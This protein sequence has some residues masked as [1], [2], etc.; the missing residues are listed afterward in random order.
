V[1]DGVGGIDPGCYSDIPN[2]VTTFRSGSYYITGTIN[3]G[4]MMTGNHVMLY[5]AGT[6]NITAPNSGGH[7]E[8]SL[9]APTGGTYIGVAVFVD[10][11]NTTNWNIQDNNFQFDLTGEVYGPTASLNFSNGLN[12]NSTG[13]SLFDVYSLNIRNGNGEFLK[14][15][16]ATTFAGA[17]FLSVSLAE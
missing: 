4:N 3:V 14:S 1:P 7:H 2:T 17:A 5:L 8:L 13:C 9:V 6:G 15:N 10:A 16:C 11:A 12:I